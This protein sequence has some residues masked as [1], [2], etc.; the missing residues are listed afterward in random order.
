MFDEAEDEVNERKV[1]KAKN[2]SGGDARSWSLE[3]LMRKE[4]NKKE[5]I[6]RKDYW[7]REGIVVKVMTH[8]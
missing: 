2:G 5:R 7:L 8:E 3:E 6:N 1:K 4:E